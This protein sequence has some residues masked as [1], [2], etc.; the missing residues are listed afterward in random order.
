MSL[1]D[2]L[3][4]SL[5]VGGAPEYLVGVAFREIGGLARHLVWNETWEADILCEGSRVVPP[6][7]LRIE[8][9]EC[10]DK[11]FIGTTAV[12]MVLPDDIPAQ[13]HILGVVA[14]GMRGGHGRG[15]Y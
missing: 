14:K 15:P 2:A 10:A 8:F 4:P 6:K 13:A 7:P 3:R 1:N 12:R 5:K 9:G 11:G